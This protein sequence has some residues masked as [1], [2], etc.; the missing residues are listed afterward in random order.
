MFKNVL[1]APRHLSKTSKTRMQTNSRLNPKVKLMRSQ[2]SQP[3][4]QYSK[5]DWHRIHQFCS[6]QFLQNTLL[7]VISGDPNV[8]VR[9]ITRTSNS[10]SGAVAELEIWRHMTHHFTG[11]SKTRK[12]SLLKLIMS[13]AEWNVEKSKDIIQQCYHWLELISKYEALNG[14]KVSDFSQ[15]YLNTSEW[16]RQFSAITECQHQRE[17]YM[18]SDSCSSYQLL[19]QCIPN[20]DKRHLSIQRYRQERGNQLCQ[21]G[22][23]TGQ[24]QKD[25]KGCH[26]CGVCS[27]SDGYG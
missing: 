13:P 9:R 20:R 23:G 21:E 6:R 3:N 22:K 5:I 11:S 16:Q 10:D 12:V 15:D 26:L 1:S 27:F 2:H 17:C 7:H 25:L 19:Q 14:E 24:S 4:F 8:M 18:G